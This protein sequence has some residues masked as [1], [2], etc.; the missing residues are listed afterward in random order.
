MLIDWKKQI[1]RRQVSHEV[2]QIAWVMQYP[3]QQFK[4]NL[5]TLAGV[6]SVLFTA[7]PIAAHFG[8]A[9]LHAMNSWNT[10]H[11]ENRRRRQSS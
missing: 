8:I 6:L 1:V 5:D 10:A 3:E 7:K 11:D 2:F 4:D 9:G